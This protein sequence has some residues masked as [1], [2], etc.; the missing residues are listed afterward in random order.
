MARTKWK[1]EK[2]KKIECGAGLIENWREKV[3][4]IFIK[5]YKKY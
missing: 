5:I 2:E 1:N 3:A 4:R